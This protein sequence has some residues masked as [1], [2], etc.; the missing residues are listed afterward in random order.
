MAGRFDGKVVMVT[1]ATG[2]LGQAAV[3]AYAAEGA[4]IVLVGRGEGELNQMIAEMGG[5]S[6]RY[7]AGAAD[8]GDVAGVDAL[9]QKVEAQ[10]G[11]IDVLAHTVGGFASGQP[12]HEAGIDVWDKM[13]NL[14]ARTVYVTCSCVARH[15]VEKGV[16]GKIVAIL[17]KHAYGG[18]AKA[19]AYSASKAA[20][21]RVLESM[22]AE[23]GSKGINVNGIV[24]A[25]ID[26][27]QNRA[28][29]PNADYSKWVKP[30]EIAQ[31][32]LFLTSDAARSINGAS[33]NMY[34]QG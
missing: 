1:G 32:I 24:P 19:A 27:P 26:T 6:A 5:D 7:M 23:L 31:T 25:M 10:F 3:Q 16:Q 18:V 33:I 9:I 11:Q 17:S 12:A 15:M 8:V 13:M 21:Q 2:N 30:E 29:S 14:N 22:A 28:S 4:K 34:G 20:A